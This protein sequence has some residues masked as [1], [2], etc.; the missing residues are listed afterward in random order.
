MVRKVFNLRK[1]LNLEEAAEHLSDLLSEPVT[2]KDI[3]NLALDGELTLSVSFLSDY[4]TGFICEPVTKEDDFLW[5][6]TSHGFVSTKTEV[7]LHGI[8]DLPMIA[9]NKTIVQRIGFED[10]D[11]SFENEI[12]LAAE[13]GEVIELQ[14]TLFHDDGDGQRYTAKESA[15]D[16]PDGA[17]I[18][19]RPTA[20]AILAS[21]LAVGFRMIAYRFREQV[22]V[23]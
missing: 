1:W 4:E 11:I 14:R 8:Y 18:C 5:G 17:T 19:V 9:G 21:R 6:L 7:N 15:T 16:L 12:F 2:V 23:G 10:F 20:L 3:R 22:W 13:S